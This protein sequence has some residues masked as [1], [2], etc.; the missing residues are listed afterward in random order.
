MDVAAAPAG[1]WQGCSCKWSDPDIWFQRISGQ[2]AHGSLKDGGPTENDG[3]PVPQRFPWSRMENGLSADSLPQASRVGRI[4]VLGAAGQLGR[5]AAAAFRVAGW[6]VASLVRGHAS[7]AIAPGTELVEVDARDTGAVI[8]AARGAEVVLHALNVPYTQWSMV[9]LPLAETAIA[10][11]GENG[12]TLVFPGNLYIYGAGIPAI[13][14]ETAAVRPTSRK[15]EIRAAIEARMRAA[16]DQGLRVIILR[17]GDFFGGS[18]IGSYF[19]RILVREVATGRLTYPG[20]LGVVHEWAYVPDLCEAMLRLVEARTALE[21][22]AQFGFPG[23]AVTGRALAGAIS[24]ACGR[25]FK[26][27]GM[28]WPLLRMLGVVVPIFRELS[29]VA[30][31]WSTPHAI[32]GTRLRT[33]IGDPPLTPLDRA[34]AAALLNLGIRRRPEGRR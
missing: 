7:A 30:Y 8:A 11:A 34:V 15:G 27:N 10:A 20:P 1:P 17:G 5:A 33:V 29:E 6:Q 31:L 13:V 2:A 26:V 21:P 3:K 25:G 16:S 23:H 32:D 19:D 28:P 12:A 22:F 9:A 18:G 14:D 24:R 4:L